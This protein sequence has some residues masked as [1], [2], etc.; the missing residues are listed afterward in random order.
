VPSVTANINIDVEDDL[1]RAIEAVDSLMTT[2][3]SSAALGTAMTISEI[4]IELMP[5]CGK[6][7]TRRH[8]RALATSLA[9]L[10]QRGA[11]S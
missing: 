9:I 10:L 8:C 2:L 11:F 3:R 5:E 7:A 4:V 1:V 6:R